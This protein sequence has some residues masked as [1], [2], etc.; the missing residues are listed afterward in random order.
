[1]NKIAIIGLSGQS[2]FLNLEQLPTPSVTS[3]SKT[4]FIEAG[5]KG[6]NQ[7]VACKKNGSDVSYFSKIGNDYYGKIVKE[8]LDN[9]QI[10]SNFIVD[11]TSSTAIATILTDQKGEN[12]VIVYP[13]AS[14]KLTVE[15]LKQFEQQIISS[16]IL[17]LQYEIPLEVIKKSIEIA[18]KNQILVIVNPAPAI[19]QDQFILNN[20][21]ILTPN[22]EEAK[23]IF[24]LQNIKMESLGPI[25][26]NTTSQTLIITLGKNGCLLIKDH[27]YQ[28]FNAYKCNTVDTTGAGDVFNAG[29]ASIINKDMSNIIEAIQYAQAAAA[30][31]VTKK[32]VM[33]AIPTYNEVKKFQQLYNLKQNH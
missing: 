16:D 29:I 13:G 14:N 28:Y 9:L 17:L 30:I 15:D 11:Q 12:E 25:L 23:K 26:A 3:H 19:Y 1:M 8:Y 31:S 10:K 20:A 18:K 24:N 2:I 32:H 4:C 21:D 6:Y 7:A 22:F 27:Q 5:G 33:D